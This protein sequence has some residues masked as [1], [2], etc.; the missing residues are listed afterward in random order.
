MDQ[1]VFKKTERKNM[2]IS[3]KSGRMLRVVNQM[4]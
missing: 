3:I 2:E 4:T 1:S